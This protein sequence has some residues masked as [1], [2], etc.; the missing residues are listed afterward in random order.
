MPFEFIH[1]WTLETLSNLIRNRLMSLLALS[2]VA[3]GLFILGGFYLSLA[4]IR[5]MVKTQ[6]GKLNIT[7][8][9]DPQIT[10]RR[11]KEIYEAS[12]IPQVAD[13]QIRTKDQVL[14]EMHQDTPG[15][16]VDDLKGKNNP[17]SDEIRIR[18]KD[19]QTIPA[20]RAYMETL[21]GKGVDD[22]ISDRDILQKLLSLNR[23][24]VIIGTVSLIVLGLAIL[25]IIYNTIRLTV[26]ARRREIRIMELVGATRGFIRV[27]FVLEGIIIGFFGALLAAALLVS[28]HAM[29]G[30]MMPPFLRTMSPATIALV[31]KQCA[32][33]IMLS[34]LVFG[35]IGSCISLNRSIDKAALQ[36]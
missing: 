13:L 25:A 6:T 15:I 24:L 8:I 30:N 3:I 5:E 31:S 26:H 33:G 20:V 12:R 1:F 34:G 10:A 36:N 4:H 7:V 22:T 32:F 19:P 35:L 16:S 9:L 27:P 11:R 2:T 23:L 21:K 18:V 28:F 17:L 29:L 14:M